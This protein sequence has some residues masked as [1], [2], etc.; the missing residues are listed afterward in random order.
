MISSRLTSSALI[1]AINNWYLYHCVVYSVCTCG[2][3]FTNSYS[4]RSSSKSRRYNNMSMYE[5]ITAVLS[6]R[7]R[8]QIYA[9]VTVMTRATVYFVARHPLPLSLSLFAAVCDC[10]WRCYR[11]RRHRFLIR[12]GCLIRFDSSH[13]Q[14]IFALYTNTRVFLCFCLATVLYMCLVGLWI[15]SCYFFCACHTHRP[16]FSL[17]RCVLIYVYMYNDRPYN[18]KSYDVYFV[19]LV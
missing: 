1:H 15:S 12:R 13:N 16:P 5:C 9:I 3:H 4:S 2:G 17:S 8:M 19:P 7:A 6:Q 10:R 18:M 11:S 14:E